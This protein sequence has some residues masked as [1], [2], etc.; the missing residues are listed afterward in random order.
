MTTNDFVTISACIKE[1]SFNFRDVMIIQDGVSTLSMDVEDCRL[2]SDHFCFLPGHGLVCICPDR[3]GHY[4]D[5]YMLIK[6]IKQY[7]LI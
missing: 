1:A 2:L 6:I 7:D 3:W 4:D 5:N